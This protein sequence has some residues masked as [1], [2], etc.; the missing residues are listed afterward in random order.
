MEGTSRTGKVD[1]RGGGKE[2]E[3]EEEEQRLRGM[4]YADHADIVSRSSEGLDRK[5]T[6]IVTACSAFGLTISEAKTEIM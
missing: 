4:L 3:E 6:V 1:G 5:M 2:E